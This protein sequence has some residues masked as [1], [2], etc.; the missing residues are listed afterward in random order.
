MVQ[1]QVRGYREV[2]SRKTDGVAAVSASIREGARAR[3]I[4][5]SRQSYKW[6]IGAAMLLRIELEQDRKMEASS[7]LM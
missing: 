5:A 4:T 3:I 1:E 6:P 2:E 7:L